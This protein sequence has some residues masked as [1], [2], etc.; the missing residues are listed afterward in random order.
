MVRDKRQMTIWDQNEQLG[1]EFE[2][3]PMGDY[4]A[5]T[6]RLLRDYLRKYVKLAKKHDFT[7]ARLDEF[8]ILHCE[9]I[10]FACMTVEACLNYIGFLMLGEIYFINHIE[11][12]SIRQKTALLFAIIRQE[13]IADDDQLVRDID[14]LFSPRNARVHPKCSRIKPG[15]KPRLHQLLYEHEPDPDLLRGYVSALEMIIDR[16]TELTPTRTR[17]YL[18]ISNQRIRP[19]R[20]RPR[21]PR[22]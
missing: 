15:K 5:Q 8:S 17:K 13:R 4:Y 12:V 9:L 18:D 6:H 20:V 22:R 3:P 11:R 16:L 1:L 19:V 14:H 2:G 7:L 21:H 10:L